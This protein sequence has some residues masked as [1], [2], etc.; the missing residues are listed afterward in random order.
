[1]SFVTL[2]NKFQLRKWKDYQRWFRRSIQMDSRCM[3]WI[4]PSST[5][6]WDREVAA[7]GWSKIDRP[8]TAYNSLTL[9]F[10]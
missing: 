8:D 1:M 3:K 5:F 2:R 7:P 6:P 4:R 9:L 10:K